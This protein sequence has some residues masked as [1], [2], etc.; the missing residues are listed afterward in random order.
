MNSHLENLPINHDL[1]LPSLVALLLCFTF[2]LFFVGGLYIF[3][4][5]RI[6]GGGNDLLTKNHPKVILQRIKTVG[7]TCVLSFFGVW[8]LISGYD[9]FTDKVF[10]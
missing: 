6:G 9:G 8:A 7:L 5:T 2:V 1:Q 4:D 3:K 10:G